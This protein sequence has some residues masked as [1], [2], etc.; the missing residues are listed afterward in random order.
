MNRRG[1]TRTRQVMFKV[2]LSRRERS[3]SCIKQATGGTRAGRDHQRFESPDTRPPSNRRIPA[4]PGQFTRT[5]HVVTEV[6][7]DPFTRGLEIFVAH[8][9]TEALLLRA[10]RCV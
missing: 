4:T 3:C 1:E 8:Q 2:G 7:G 10:R 5:R 9:E 6:R